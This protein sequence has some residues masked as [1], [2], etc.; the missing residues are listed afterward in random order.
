MTWPQQNHS[1]Q[2]RVYF[3]GHA[4][5]SMS[6]LGIA[7]LYIDMHFGSVIQWNLSVTT[8][9]KIKCGGI[10]F[11]LDE[12]TSWHQSYGT[13]WIVCIIL[14]AR[15]ERNLSCIYGIKFD[16]YI[17][18]ECYKSISMDRRKSKA[19]RQVRLFLFS[20]SLQGGFSWTAVLPSPV[21]PMSDWQM[22]TCVLSDLLA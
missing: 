6:L 17:S 3:M 8:T 22:F 13:S 18:Y 10:E 15:I 5:N 11:Q 4:V 7:L 21:N 16:T 9:S 12:Q 19:S 2:I 20:V 14:C 1:Q